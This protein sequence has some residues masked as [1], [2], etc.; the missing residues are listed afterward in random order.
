MGHLSVLSRSATVFDKVYLLIVHNS[1]KIAAM[2]FETRVAM[3]EGAI[4]EAGL[5]AKCSVQSLH[6][7]LLIKKAQ[8]LGA[9]AIV[10]GFRNSADIDYELPM[11]KVNHDL[12]G[13]E[14]VFIASE[15]NYGHVSSSLVKEVFALGGDISKYVTP[16]VLKKMQEGKE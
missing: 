4:A 15:G 10:K 16:S 11:A 12:A 2:D 5:A 7:G 1:S 8:E 9:N 6:S 3:A 14:T 13:I